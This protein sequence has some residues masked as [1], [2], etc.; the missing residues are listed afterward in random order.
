MKLLVFIRL[1]SN[2]LA[3]RVALTLFGAAGV[4]LSTAIVRR[5]IA[6]VLQLMNVNANHSQYWLSLS[7][8]ARENKFERLQSLVPAGT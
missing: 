2:L 4:A 7:L 8:I 6:Q 5:R 3:S 1:E